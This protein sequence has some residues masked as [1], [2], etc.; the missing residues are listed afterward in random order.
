MVTPQQRCKHGPRQRSRSRGE[1]EVEAKGVEIGPGG[2]GAAGAEVVVQVKEGHRVE[3]RLYQLADPGEAEVGDHVGVAEVE[4]ETQGRRGDALAEGAQ[5]L[6]RVPEVLGPAEDG[7][8]V[9]DRDRHSQ[10]LCQVREA[11]E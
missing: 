5:Q 7:G 1:V 4:A 10:A 11:G 9:L 3:H 2:G 8:E 6:R